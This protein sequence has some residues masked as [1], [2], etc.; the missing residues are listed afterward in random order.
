M[1]VM[2]STFVRFSAEQVPVHPDQKAPEG[3]ESIRLTSGKLEEEG[4]GFDIPLTKELPGKPELTPHREM[5]VK[6]LETLFNKS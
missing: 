1:R 2:P 5:L 6:M 3:K 4:G